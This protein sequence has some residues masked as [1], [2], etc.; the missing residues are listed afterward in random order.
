MSVKKIIFGL[1]FVL[2]ASVHAVDITINNLVGLDGAGSSGYDLPDVVKASSDWVPLFRL[3]ITT[4]AASS[5]DAYKLASITCTIEDVAN[6][7][8]DDDDLGSLTSSLGVFTDT[9]CTTSAGSLTYKIAGAAVTSWAGGGEETV[10][11]VFAAPVSLSSWTLTS[12]Y[13]AVK[14]GSGLEGDGPDYAGADDEFRAKWANDG[15]IFNVKVTSGNS[16]YNIT[17]AGAGTSDTLVADVKAPTFVTAYSP[18]ADSGQ[19]TTVYAGDKGGVAATDNVFKT[20]D[21]I[22]VTVK[23]KDEAGNTETNA[24]LRGDT[25]VITL[26]DCIEI[27]ASTILGSLGSGTTTFSAATAGAPEFKIA[28]QINNSAVNQNTD[29][30]TPLTFGIKVKDGAGNETSMNTS[31]EIYLD[32]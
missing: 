28:F 1:L 21:T 25:S 23:L 2:S 13:I 19:T 20:G 29:G 17:A 4:V 24:G 12:F 8:T 22:T 32:S 10:E 27:S 16:I 18:A 26:N 14:T 31:F 11:I 9:G 6:F 7:D 30:T 5:S 15:T 3:D